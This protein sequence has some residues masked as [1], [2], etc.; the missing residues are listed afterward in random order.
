M[1]FDHCPVDQLSGVRG[2]IQKDVR[3]NSGMLEFTREPK[4]PIM[5]LCGDRLSLLQEPILKFSGRC[6]GV[7]SQWSQ[8]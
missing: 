5:F 2:S 7:G 8:D 4:C 3:V 1:S 6:L